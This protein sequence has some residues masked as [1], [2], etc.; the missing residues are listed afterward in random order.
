EIRGGDL[1][2][3]EPQL[4]S[5]NVRQ[6]GRQAGG[7]VRI[8]HALE[9]ALGESCQRGQRDP[10]HVE[11]QSDG[12]AVEIAA[13]EHVAAEYKRIVRGGVQLRRDRPF[14]EAEPLADR[15]QHLWRAAERIGVL[16][17]R[18]VLSWRLA[19]RA[20]GEQRTEQRRRA[21]LPGVRPRVMDARVERIW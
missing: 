20:V 6:K 14:G 4:K 9:P 11:R 7:E 21:L 8:H 15:S 10:D 16:Y 12:L 17:P 18:V 3:Q 19:D 13:G 1:G 2:R 5:R